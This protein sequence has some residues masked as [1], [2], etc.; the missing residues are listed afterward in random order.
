[1]NIEGNIAIVCI[2]ENGKKFSIKYSISNIKWS[3]LSS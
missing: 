2:T 3:C 1:M